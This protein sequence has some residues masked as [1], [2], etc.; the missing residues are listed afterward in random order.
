MTA[1]HMLGPFVGS[2]ALGFHSTCS[3]GHRVEGSS[4][5]ELRAGHQKHV[6]ALALRPGVAKARQALAES[7][8]RGKPQP[9][10]VQA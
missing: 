2:D 1:P 4:R 6:G 5:D 3:C 10:E 7:L 8:E 9:A